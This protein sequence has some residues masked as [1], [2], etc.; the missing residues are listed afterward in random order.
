MDLQMKFASSFLAAG[1]LTFSLAFAQ[2][3]PRIWKP[4]QPP[5]KQHQ[6]TVEQLGYDKGLIF[7]A[8]ESSQVVYFPVP[9]DMG[10]WSGTLLVQYRVS[11]LLIQPSNL[12]VLVGD[13]PVKAVP[14]SAGTETVQTFEMPIDGRLL[15]QR[16]LK[17]A[18]AASARTTNDA[19]TDEKMRSNFVHIM[20]GTALRITSEKPYATT[21]RGVVDLLPET[22]VVSL[23][24][25]RLSEDVFAAA[26]RV[27]SWLMQ[28]RHQVR[29]TRLPEIGNIVV[30]PSGEIAASTGMAQIP[31]PYRQP[32]SLSVQ[33]HASG[34]YLAIAEPFQLG[35]QLLE[36]EWLAI[37][38]GEQYATRPSHATAQPTPQDMTYKLAG[39]NFAGAA[40]ES[41]AR[42]EWNVSLGPAELPPHYRIREMSL[43]YIAAP[44]VST[45]PVLMH[46]YLNRSLLH[47]FR[48]PDDGE[49][50]R[51]TISVPEGFA[52][53]QYDFRFVA[54]RL[55]REGNCEVIAASLPVQILPGTSFRA[56]YGQT[57]P[58]S[59]DDAGEYLRRGFALYTD[60]VH[61]EKPEEA[62][63]FL[64]R[65]AKALSLPIEKAQIVVYSAG[66]A[67]HPKLPFLLLSAHEPEGLAT[68]VRFN[69]G[70]I[71][72]QDPSGR[73]LLNADR[74]PGV[75][76]AQ[77]VSFENQTGV[78]I[79]PA[80]HALPDVAVELGL[81]DVA[82]LDRTGL[83]RAYNSRAMDLSQ[84]RYPQFTDWP[85]LLRQYRYWLFAALWLFLT[86]G[87]VQLYRRVTQKKEMA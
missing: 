10:Q 86:I 52:G 44:R 34:S 43:E 47:S 21:V 81:G 62:L 80:E 65:M 61:L 60:P 55:L 45:E 85:D 16:Q 71:E 57:A 38:Q 66:K 51:L 70:P 40:I 28:T 30:A 26:W 72:I 76:V 64:A 33:A 32:S 46:I 12:R 50:H 31:S 49:P 24:Q 18:F 3:A 79:R 5:P 42:A 9:R 4:Q 8:V 27:T 6:I 11:P 83:V 36:P 35:L 77:L 1:L 87:F 19:C 67:F 74:L 56:S 15:A 54:Q 73:V 37:A 53:R 7:E 22:V 69:R 2:D 48:L 82:F 20:P 58:H 14:I 29:F 17:V 25:H 39:L 68:P 13:I 63:S 41:A 59:I 23:P 75:S 84:L 78:W